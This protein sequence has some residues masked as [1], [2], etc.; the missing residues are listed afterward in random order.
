MA[1]YQ[2]LKSHLCLTSQTHVLHRPRLAV[3]DKHSAKP[4]WLAILRYASPAT[5]K[6]E[7]R[8][9]EVCGGQSKGCPPW[10]GF[11]EMQL[12][13]DLIIKMG[14]GSVGGL[15][16]CEDPRWIPRTHKGEEHSPVIPVLETGGCLG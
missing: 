3:S 4:P 15:C 14:D 16:K 13:K 12:S 9:V 6:A 1:A 11:V 10:N 7:S 8:L 2:C 5:V